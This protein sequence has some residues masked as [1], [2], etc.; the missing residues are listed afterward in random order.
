MI[1]N[2]TTNTYELLFKLSFVKSHLTGHGRH[3]AVVG[4]DPVTFTFS[5]ET[6]SGTSELSSLVRSYSYRR[7]LMCSHWL[8]RHCLNP[9]EF[10]EEG[11]PAKESLTCPIKQNTPIS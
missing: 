3:V 6:V 11:L 9:Q 5:H 8:V 4:F 10:P 1:Y 2:E 7:G